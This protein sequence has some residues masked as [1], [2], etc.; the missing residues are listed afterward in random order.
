MQIYLLIFAP[1]FCIYIYIYISPYIIF[2]FPCFGLYFTWNFLPLN[3]V[4]CISQH[5][6]F[7]SCYIFLCKYTSLIILLSESIDLSCFEISSILSCS[8]NYPLSKDSTFFFNSLFF[9]IS[10]YCFLVSLSLYNRL[11][12]LSSSF[13]FSLYSSLLVVFFTLAPWNQ[14]SNLF[15]SVCNSVYIPP[16]LLPFLFLP[17]SLPFF[18][19]LSLPFSPPLSL[20]FFL[21]SHSPFFSSFL[22]IYLFFLSFLLCFLLSS[23]SS[24]F[25]SLSLCSPLVF[26]LYL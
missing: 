6:C 1:S 8:L 26:Q 20:P 25:L 7:L 22:I 11:C 10:L 3:F 23:C 5:L 2:F 4:I 15:T 13:L 17:L 24:L 12:Q 9:F 14:L 16:L 21:P 18:P 19:P